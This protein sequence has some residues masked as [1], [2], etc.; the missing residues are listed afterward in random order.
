MD[1]RAAS[2]AGGGPGEVHIAVAAE[3]AGGLIE[4][5]LAGGGLGAVAGPAGQVGRDVLTQAERA[6]V[7]AFARL[8]F[9]QR[10][11]EAF[12]T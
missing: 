12:Q 11:L 4:A 6:A 7:F 8:G 5:V 1:R 2:A 10:P 9:N 3:G